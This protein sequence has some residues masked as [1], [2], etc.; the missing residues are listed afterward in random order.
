MTIKLKP[1]PGEKPE[2]THVDGFGQS[3]PISLVTGEPGGVRVAGVG[4]GGRWAAVDAKQ[5]RAI[6]VWAGRALRWMEK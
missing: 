3:L 1:K 4:I 6:R 5:L 2:P